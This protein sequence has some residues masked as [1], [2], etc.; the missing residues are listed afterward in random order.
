MTWVSEE[1]REVAIVGD[2]EQ[3]LA[4]LVEAADGVELDVPDGEEIEDRLAALVVARGGE[5]AGGLVEHEVPVATAKHGDAVNH[6]LVEVGVG[7]GAE[8]LTHFTVY[9]HAAGEDHLLGRA[10]RGDTGVGEDLLEALNGHDE[11]SSRG[12]PLAPSG[13]MRR[14]HPP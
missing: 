9:A 4:V 3:A 12:G 10:A 13:R 14:L 1:T 5:K 6:D 11:P 8:G 2:Q 7:P